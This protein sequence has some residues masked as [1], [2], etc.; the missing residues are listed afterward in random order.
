MSGFLGETMLPG[1]AFRSGQ[2]WQQ[3]EKEERQHD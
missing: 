2:G 3:R 1:I